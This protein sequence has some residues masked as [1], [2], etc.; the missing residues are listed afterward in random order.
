MYVHELIAGIIGTQLAPVLCI[1]GK[2]GGCVVGCAGIVAY[3]CVRPTKSIIYVPLQVN[4]FQKSILLIV[5]NKYLKSCSKDLILHNLILCTRL[6][7][8]GIIT[9]PSWFF[10]ST[11][12]IWSGGNILY[13]SC[14]SSE[15]ASRGGQPLNILTWFIGAGGFA[16]V[17]AYACV[18]ARARESVCTCACEYVCDCLQCIIQ[19][20]VES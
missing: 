8:T 13:H 9:Q 3:V 15:G 10:F 17:R 14:T 12:S 6:C 19:D 11:W 16:C 4:R 18:R 5:Q 1:G 2:V 7:G 20:G